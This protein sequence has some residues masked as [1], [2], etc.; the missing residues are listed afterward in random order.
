M[1]CPILAAHDV[2][3]TFSSSE[4]AFDRPRLL[5]A[6]AGVT[7]EISRGRSVGIAGESGCGKSTLAKLLTGLLPASSGSVSYDGKPLADL[8]RDEQRQF[9]RSVQ[10]IFQD[11]FSSLNPRLR[12]GRII[13]EP[14]TIHRLVPPSAIDQEVSRLL[15]TVGLPVDAASRY[16]HEFSGGQRQ[17]I[18]IAR[19][20][21]CR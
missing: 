1:N 14:L 12:V 19:A 16:P 9:R 3:R 18:G 13:S 17:R 6:V 4:G 21:D 11:P 10:M 5:T 8:S 7:L 20:L 2:Y 15:A